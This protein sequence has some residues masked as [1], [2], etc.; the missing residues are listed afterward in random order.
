MRRQQLSKII[1][2]ILNQNDELYYY[3]GFHDFVS[4]FLMTLGE[5]LGYH[6]ANIASNYLIKDFMLVNFELG[7]FPALDLTNKLLELI[8]NDLFEL[9]E[10]IGG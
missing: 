9:V 8:D 5:N 6:C 2:A 3:Q 7:V 1:H 10:L 4:I